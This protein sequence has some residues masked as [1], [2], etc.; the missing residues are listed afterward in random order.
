M[1]RIYISIVGLIWASVANVVPTFAQ[2]KDTK[3]LAA[4]APAQSAEGGWNLSQTCGVLGDLEVFINQKKIRITDVATGIVTS[5]YAPDWKVVTVDQKT[6]SFAESPLN[7]FKGYIE[8]REFVDPGTRWVAL[9]LEPDQ[10][11]K[12]AGVDAVSFKTPPTFSEKQIKDWTQ[13]SASSTFA[14]SARYCVAKNI[15]V[16]KQATEVLCRFYQLPVK[17]SLPLQFKY[18]NVANNLNTWLFTT[19]VSP[20]TDF[21]AGDSIPPGFTKAVSAMEVKNSLR[22]TEAAKKVKK[23]RPLL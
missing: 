9:P 6:K 2:S 20:G 22:K 1:K 11:T 13:E 7:N 23:K 19:R 21:G 8:D 16:P 15:A 5:S 14:K 17:T 10:P 12:I 3:P 18:Y 4:P